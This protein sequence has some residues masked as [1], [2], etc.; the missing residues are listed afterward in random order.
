MSFYQAVRFPTK[1]VLQSFRRDAARS[2]LHAALSAVAAL[3]NLTRLGLHLEASASDQTWDSDKLLQ[4]AWVALAPR[5]EGLRVKYRSYDV[6]P[7]TLRLLDT[8]LLTRLSV[9]H[10]VYEA[11]GEN[12]TFGA[13]G[14]QQ[15]IVKFIGPLAATVQ[16]LQLQVNGGMSPDA[17]FQLFLSLSNHSFA[18][19]GSLAFSLP[20][21]VFQSPGPSGLH[22][23]VDNC[24]GTVHTYELDYRTSGA[25][26]NVGYYALL[27]RHV[28]ALPMLRSLTVHAPPLLDHDL[29]M[30]QA[31]ET[32]A[33]SEVLQATTGNL[34]DLRIMQRYALLFRPFQL[35]AVVSNAAAALAS[36]R[37]LY[38]DLYHLTAGQFGSLVEGLPLLESLEVRVQRWVDSDGIEYYVSTICVNRMQQ[39]I[40]LTGP[41][42][43]YAA[44][45]TGTMRDRGV[46]PRDRSPWPIVQS[47]LLPGP[48][49]R[50][51]S[52]SRLGP[53]YGPADVRL[54]AAPPRRVLRGIPRARRGRGG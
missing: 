37:S 36:L 22:L 52:L 31:K 21:V 46:Y 25:T 1:F 30:T 27:S 24:G 50:S 38:V 51:R 16:E 8:R 5:L 48:Q 11:L 3:P 29:S 2:Q 43:L 13:G 28:K 6:G 17:C 4:K 15:A 34:R 49:E 20:E 32:S 54:P 9:F 19:L 12:T 26:I 7:Q 23:F 47:A 42:S 33:L 44:D 40:S 53:I 10:L 18:N 45:N 14:S 35:L 41:F 39:L